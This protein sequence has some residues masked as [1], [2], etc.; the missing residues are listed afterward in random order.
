M[1]RHPASTSIDILREYVAAFERIGPKLRSLLADEGRADD[2]AGM[3]IV[4]AII[5]DFEK[6]QRAASQGLDELEARRHRQAR[7]AKVRA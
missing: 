1:K 7:T 4:S 5:A 2:L 6:Q 3:C